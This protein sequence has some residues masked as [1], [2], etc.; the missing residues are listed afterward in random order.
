M[1][2]TVFL[3]SLSQAAEQLLQYRT[4][5][6]RQASNWSQLFTDYT[7]PA[8]AISIFSPLSDP[9]DHETEFSQNSQRKSQ[10]EQIWEMLYF[11]PL[12]DCYQSI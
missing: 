6:A 1:I 11:M 10:A 7:S 8:L 12:R 5:A 4:Q 3:A 9:G 2:N